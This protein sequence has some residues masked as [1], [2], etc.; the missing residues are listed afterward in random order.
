[1]AEIEVIAPN[2]KK[3]LSGVTSVII[4]IVPE[5]R[6]LGT[7]VCALGPGLPPHVPKLRL[8]DLPRLLSRP[9]RRP[10]RV[11]HAR[12]NTEML[13]GLVL[14]QVLR[15]PVKL[16]FTSAAQRSHTAYTRWLMRHMDA[17]V[18][19]SS[20]SA[21]FLSLPHRIV[22]HGIDLERFHPPSE[23]ER[24]WSSSGLPGTHGIGC[25][26]RIRPQKGTDLFVDAMIELLPH[27]PEWTAAIFGR[28]TSDHR[29]FAETLQHRIDAAGL[30]ERIVF[31][32]EVPDIKPWYR[33][34]SVCVAPSRNEGFGLTP[35]E[36]M[37][38][39]TA[40]VASDAGAYRD[41]VAEGETGFVVGAGDG[42]ALTAAIS[43]YLRAPDLAARHAE[44]GLR[45]AREHY[46]LERE[47]QALAEVYEHLWSGA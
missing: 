15:A 26:G 23:E 2:F 39:Q 40:V 8:R 32:G 36:A 10:V 38:S 25:F 46:A 41:L 37:A 27:H 34:I 14:R 19:T 33:R 21:S 1:M 22:P 35:L 7:V 29:R 17:I 5:Q 43:T 44:A 9:R 13:A 11:W 12:R 24:D 30:A 4:Q 20:R 47:V 3:R 6:R 45:R 28:V 42:A 16:V 18:T 31:M